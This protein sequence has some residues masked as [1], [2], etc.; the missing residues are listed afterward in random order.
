MLLDEWF[1]YVLGD[2]ELRLDGCAD[3]LLKNGSV[4]RSLDSS[5]AVWVAHPEHG[6]R[7][8]LA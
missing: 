1:A 6:T 2:P 8:G 7:E 4:F 5:M 3:A